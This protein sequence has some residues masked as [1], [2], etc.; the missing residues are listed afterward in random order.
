MPGEPPTLP[1]PER[2]STADPPKLKIR[3]GSG[4]SSQSQLTATTPGGGTSSPRNNGPTA[5]SPL[6]ARGIVAAS[7]LS[8][9]T[10]AGTPA[11]NGH[12]VPNDNGLPNLPVRGDDIM[13]DAGRPPSASL[14]IKLGSKG[15]QRA[16][17]QDGNN[18]DDG[19]AQAEQLKREAEE[20]LRTRQQLENDLLEL[21]D[22]ARQHLVPLYE[23]V[24]KVVARSFSEL[25]SLVEM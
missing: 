21:P 9:S 17:D 14:K 3:L 20:I 10:P 23:V 22:V 12:H 13:Q 7:P 15:K 11:E 4:R 8:I 24:R 2:R 1:A 5:P 19:N 25:Q 16:V 6:V 18:I